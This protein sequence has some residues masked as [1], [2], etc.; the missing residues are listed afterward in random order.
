MRRSSNFQSKPKSG[1]RDTDL[2]LSPDLL[3]DIHDLEYCNESPIGQGAF[4]TVYK[5]KL[6]S[7]NKDAA[8]KI[9]NLDILQSKSSQRL[10]I[11]IVKELTS[12]DHPNVLKCFGLCPEKGGII[13]QL[14]EK[15]IT[16][17]SKE[18]KVNSL[19]QLINV[20]GDDG[21]LPNWL[22]LDAMFQITEGLDYLHN[23]KVYHGDLK[24][25]NVLVSETQDTEFI[26]LLADFGQPQSA[27]TSL[28]GISC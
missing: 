20:I 2:Q 10:L 27:I 18:V 25:A 16:L 23:K 11:N 6:K 13:L 8:L 12:L 17:D 19:R 21:E 28:Q 22:V 7:R 1:G 14:A 3:I 15:T 26:F 24:S 9:Y 5:E 4:G